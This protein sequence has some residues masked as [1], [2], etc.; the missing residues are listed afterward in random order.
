MLRIKRGA[1]L[2]HAKKDC[3][4]PPEGWYYDVRYVNPEKIKGI[5][6]ENF[7]EWELVEKISDTYL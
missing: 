4:C 7:A 3:Y 2:S 6:V 5:E 1:S